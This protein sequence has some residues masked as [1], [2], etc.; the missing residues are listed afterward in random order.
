MLLAGFG[1]F[2]QQLVHKQI[3]T[4]R[5]GFFMAEFDGAVGIRLGTTYS[6]V[7]VWQNETVQIIPDDQVFPCIFSLL[8]RTNGGQFLHHFCRATGEPPLLCH[9]RIHRTLLVMRQSLRSVFPLFAV[10]ATSLNAIV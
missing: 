7:A 6:C 2:L 3:T 8:F 1:R 10:G 4:P 5:Q 9:S